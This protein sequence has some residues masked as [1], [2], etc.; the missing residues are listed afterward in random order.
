MASNSRRK[1]TELVAQ[2]SHW[3][4]CDFWPH[5]REALSILKGISIEKTYIVQLPYTIS[6]TFS[7]Q[8][9]GLTKDQ[10]C[11]SG[12]INTPLWHAQRCQWHRCDFWPHVRE[13]LPTLRGKCIEKTYIVKLPYTI[14]I[15]FTQQIWG[16]LSQRCHWHRWDQNQ[17][18][19]SRFSSRNWSHFEK[20][21]KLCIRRL[22]RVLW[23]HSSK[24][25]F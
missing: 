8:I 21:F 2:Q 16:F 3:H 18:F 23:V 7:Q 5:I 17:R 20:G 24:I 25:T 19:R 22:W 15:T 1:L 14:S 12:A 11:H 9:W 13:A 4:R 10:F 6:I